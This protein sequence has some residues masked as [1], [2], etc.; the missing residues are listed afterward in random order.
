MK[1]RWFIINVDEWWVDEGNVFW[2]IKDFYLFLYVDDDYHDPWGDECNI[3]S[4]DWLLFIIPYLD[5]H[6]WM[7]IMSHEAY[8][9][10]HK[11]LKSLSWMIRAESVNL[12]FWF[13]A[14]L[15]NSSWKFWKSVQFPP[16]HFKKRIFLF[17]FCIFVKSKR[18][19]LFIFSFFLFSLGQIFIGWQIFFS[20]F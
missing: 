19:N 11:W 4:T 13:L 1:K 10:T 5:E 12:F 7:M 6:E 15:R 2:M 17:F 8:I 18:L 3:C 9:I 20:K 14:I 16:C